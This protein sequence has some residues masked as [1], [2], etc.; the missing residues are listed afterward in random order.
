MLRSLCF[1]ERGDSSYISMYSNSLPETWT[2]RCN[3]L[4]RIFAYGPA[5][6]AV[7]KMLRLQCSRRQ[8]PRG[9]VQC[10]IRSR[11]RVFFHFWICFTVFLTVGKCAARGGCR[12]GRRD[13]GADLRNDATDGQSQ[14]QVDGG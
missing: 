2:A 3:R 6:V 7:T 9:S 11:R 8:D 12:D 13:E 14:G 4:C 1:V 10:S 5:A